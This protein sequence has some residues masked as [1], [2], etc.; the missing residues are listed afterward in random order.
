M[1]NAARFIGQS[2]AR[3][4]DRRLLTGRGR[5]VD[6][7]Q[8]PGTLH[9]VFVR[10]PIARGR[11][12]GIDVAS[13]RSAPGV[14]AVLTAADINPIVLDMRSTIEIFGGMPPVD[15]REP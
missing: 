6:D 5:Y 2:V 12:V 1:N 15:F 3:K 13:A 4:E 11:I 10:S 7:I 9:A 14:R 8:L